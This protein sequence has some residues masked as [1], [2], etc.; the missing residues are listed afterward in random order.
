MHQTQAEARSLATAVVTAVGGQ[1][2]VQVVLAPP[3]TALAA[4]A[5]VTRGSGVAVAAQNMHWAAQGP[6][7][8]EVSPVMV[9]ELASHVILGH[10]ERRT[11]FGETDEGVNRKVHAAVAQALVPIVCVGET[12]A[13]RD[14]AVTDAVVTRQLTDGLAGL[15]ETAFGALVIAYE[16]VWA[17]GTGRACDAAEAGR[18]AGVIRAWLT[19]RSVAAADAVR[20]LYG[21]SV[22]ANNA[23]ELLHAPDVDGA[24]VG[25]ASLAAASFVAIVE[26]A[27]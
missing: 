21:G 6:Y 10:S 8:G 1:T 22:T 24:L 4:V 5:E 17:I 26:A 12:A 20:V 2:R 27:A 9:A 19:A 7:T 11:L 3:S 18:V 13:E 14:A 16:P 25:G 15:A 23:R